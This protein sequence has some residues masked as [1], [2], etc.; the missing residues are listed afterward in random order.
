MKKRH[1]VITA[2]VTFYVTA[3]FFILI[4]A[5]LYFGGFLSNNSL[6]T[7]LNKIEALVENSFIFD[8]TKD[9]LEES[10]LEGY[11]K[12]CDDVYTEYIS[13]SE[14]ISYRQT[15]D[16]K[17]KGIGVVVSLY[18]R[19]VTVITVNP[20]TPASKAGIKSG[21]IIK[22]VN[23]VDVNAESYNDAI[24]IIRGSDKRGEDDNL[25]VVI[26][27]E[28][29]ELTFNIKREEVETITVSEKLLDGNIGYIRISSFEG[30]TGEQFEKSVD[31][32]LNKNV[33]GFIFDVRNNPGGT[34]EA[35]LQVTDRVLDEGIILTIR[36]KSGDEAV[37]KAEDKNN[38]KLPV[39]ILANENSASAAEVFCAALKE[40]GVAKIVGV[41][42]F[43][44][45]IVQSIYDLGDETAVKLTTAK[46]YTPNNTCIHE[47]GVSPDYEVKLSE[48]YDGV[49]IS[50]IPYYA[51]T[52]LQKAIEIIK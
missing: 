42:T 48:K 47:I 12:A 2:V 5:R 33:K 17:Y 30:T 31:N 9:E 28:G 4:G 8:Y 11:L 50:D 41:T 1:I 39:Y 15:Q 7:K 44:K 16:G 45:G 18:D 40:N 49:S 24:A 26:S 10:A 38:I 32:L 29:K 6:N 35:V 22:K 36:D 20:E 27:R 52:Q 14:Y 43:G 37:Y 3:L 51:D 23:G 46:Y 21:D 34:L 13:K 19:D 25:S